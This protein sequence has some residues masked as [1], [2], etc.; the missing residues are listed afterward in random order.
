MNQTPPGSEHQNKLL[1]MLGGP[2]AQSQSQ[3]ES[4]PNVAPPSS[5]QAINLLSMFKRYV[6]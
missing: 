4:R 3:W 2:G 5:A 6:T 1:G